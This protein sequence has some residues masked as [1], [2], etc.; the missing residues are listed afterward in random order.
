MQAL[1][2]KAYGEVTQRTADT[3]AIEYAVFEQITQALEQVQAD[4][5]ADIGLWADAL[6]RNMQLWTLITTDLLN[7]DNTLAIETKAG[8]ISLAEF[9]RRTSHQILSGEEGL[10]DIIEIN[11]TIMAGLGGAK[12]RNLQEQG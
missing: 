8:L 12:N 7:P 2:Y 6:H 4:G 5:G 11:R 3:H 10:A 9:V 1:A